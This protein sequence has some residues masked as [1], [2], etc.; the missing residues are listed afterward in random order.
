METYADIIKDTIYM[1]QISWSGLLGNMHDADA[2]YARYIREGSE[3]DIQNL[4]GPIHSKIYED[5]VLSGPTC[6]KNQLLGIPQALCSYLF[7]CIP[8]VPLVQTE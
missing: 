2:L 8:R 5:L 3:R 1:N 4:A 7:F 6:I